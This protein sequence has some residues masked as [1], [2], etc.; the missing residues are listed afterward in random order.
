[1]DVVKRKAALKMAQG[2]AVVIKDRITLRCIYRYIIQTIRLFIYVVYEDII[3]KLLV[4]NIY[5][6]TNKL[7]KFVQHLTTIDCKL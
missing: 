1:M 6:N 2:M 4:S 3:T 5:N 7:S